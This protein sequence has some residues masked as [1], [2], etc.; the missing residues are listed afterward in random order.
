MEMFDYGIAVDV[1]APPADQ[2]T[3]ITGTEFGG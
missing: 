3:A 1:E 2:V